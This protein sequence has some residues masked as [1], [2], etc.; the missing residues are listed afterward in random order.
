MNADFLDSIIEEHKSNA[1][2]PHRS[3]LSYGRF[4]VALR[5]IP[6][7]AFY[8]PKMFFDFYLRKSAFL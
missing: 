2:A 8:T 5:C 3:R 1:T 7:I 4:A 6:C